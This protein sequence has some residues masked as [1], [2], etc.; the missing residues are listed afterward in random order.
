MTAKIGWDQL[1][2][3]RSNVF[4][5]EDEYREKQESATYPKNRNASTDALRG[6]PDPTTNGGAASDAGDDEE[7][8]E[9]KD[10]AEETEKTE[11]EVDSES[12]AQTLVPNGG[13]EDIERP[14]SAVDPEGA[15]KSDENVSLFIITF[16][17]VRDY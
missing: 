12:V 5:M 15:K 9:E 16:C 13:A 2:R 10:E 14:S 8:D 11:D 4:V 3:I 6:T 7:H 17:I 1:L